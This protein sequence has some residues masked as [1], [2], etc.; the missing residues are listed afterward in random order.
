[1]VLQHGSMVIRH[2][3][4]LLLSSVNL[5]GGKA[6]KAVDRY[7]SSATSIS[8]CTA[9]EID[10]HDLEDIFF[11]DVVELAAEE[12][13]VWDEPVELAPRYHPAR[14]TATCRFG[15]VSEAPTGG[16]AHT[17]QKNRVSGQILCSRILL[18]VGGFLARSPVLG[19]VV[20]ISAP[21]I[22]LVVIFVE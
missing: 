11:Q 18:S 14:R 20:D 3:P 1:M 9:D 10:I 17:G 5:P 22:L 12:L 21:G 16:L 4:E 13:S 6:E 15:G 8:E 2:Y 19:L 7:M